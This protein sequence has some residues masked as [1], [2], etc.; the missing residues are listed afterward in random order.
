MLL[1]MSDSTLLKFDKG[2]GLEDDDQPLGSNDTS[3]FQRIW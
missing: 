3:V 1:T 2:G